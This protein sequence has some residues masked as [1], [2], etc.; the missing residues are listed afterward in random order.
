MKRLLS[1]LTGLI[2]VCS[3][4]SQEAVDLGLSVKWG[5]MNIGA[6]DIYDTGEYF[7]W[8]ETETKKG[9]YDFK[10][11]NYFDTGTNKW[12]HISM[13]LFKSGSYSSIKGSSSYDV[14]TKRLRG[15]WRMPTPYECREMAKNC[16]IK[17]IYDKNKDVYYWE[18]VSDNGNKIIVP[19]CG[20][21]MENGII[22]G[23]YFWTTKMDKNKETKAYSAQFSEGFAYSPW[24]VQTLN[25]CY[26][27]VVRPVYD[28]SPRLENSG[29]PV[30]QK[31]WKFLLYARASLDAETYSDQS[32]YL[33][34]AKKLL[35]ELESMPDVGK[36]LTHGE[37]KMAKRFLNFCTDY[38]I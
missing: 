30:E 27:L 38:R 12:G 1:L 34:E 36:I 25:R 15:Y 13:K 4:Y 18:F 9:E 3:I 17:L 26:G 8:G 24:A 2:V 35:Q 23:T 7:A 19:V 20:F 11:E 22:R 32:Y 5:S 14:A 33:G 31:L 10:W 16:K 28:D 6:S 29:N 37:L 21:K